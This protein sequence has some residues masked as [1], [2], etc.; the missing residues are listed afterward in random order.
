MIFTSSAIAPATVANQP[1][2]DQGGFPVNVLEV[3]SGSV[4]SWES[5]SDRVDLSCSVEK[6]SSGF[7][8]SIT[9]INQV[10]EQGDSNSLPTDPTQHTAGLLLLELIEHFKPQFTAAGISNFDLTVTVTK[11]IS[12]KGTGLGSSG[13]SPAATLKAFLHILPQLKIDS[14]SLSDLQADQML[15]RA[16]KG[17]PDNPIPAFHGGLT[18]FSLDS[19]GVVQSVHQHQLPDPPLFVLVTPRGFGIDTQQARKAIAGVEVPGDHEEL[20]A[21]ALEQL[22]SGNFQEYSQLMEQAH[23]W[24]VG[25]E[26]DDSGSRNRRSALY[27]DQ[28]RL[29]T[30]VQSAAKQAGAW[31]V[32]IS[33]SGPTMLAFAPNLFVGRQVGTAMSQ[34]FYRAG[35]ESVARLC[36]IDEAG[37]QLISS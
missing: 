3:V 2:F 5:L 17:V 15:Q 19:N 30:R 4:P 35:F 28:G 34:A 10:P 11:G 37:A 31:G 12:V 6:G 13:A 26:V 25:T 29:Y 1:S 18:T 21:A 33:G 23:A 9:I 16:D 36:T 24:F 8:S 14:S 22:R 20:V 27:P 7:S 32:S